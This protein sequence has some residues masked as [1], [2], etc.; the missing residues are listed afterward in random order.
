MHYTIERAAAVLGMG[1]NQL[2]KALKEKGLLTADNL[3]AGRYLYRGW[4]FV[5]TCSFRHPAVGLKHY[6]RTHITPRGLN[7]IAG[8]LGIEINH[9]QGARA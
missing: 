2:T 4:F 5:K 6:G 8:Q 7:Y 1:R 9:H 3:P